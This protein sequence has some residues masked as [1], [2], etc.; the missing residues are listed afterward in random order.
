MVTIVR[1]LC[2]LDILKVLSCNVQILDNLW[3]GDSPALWP[4]TQQEDTFTHSAHGYVISLSLLHAS[5]SLAHH[6]GLITLNNG[7][8]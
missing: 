5:G 8:H 6:K 7:N 2:I 4:Q 3:T 1:D